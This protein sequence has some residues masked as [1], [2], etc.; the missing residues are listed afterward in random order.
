MSEMGFMWLN[1][2][3]FEKY[4]QTQAITSELH[5][6]WMMQL[7]QSQKAAQQ[8]VRKTRR[9]GDQNFILP[10]NR[11]AWWTIGAWN[12]FPQFICLLL[13]PVL[14]VSYQLSSMPQ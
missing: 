12:Y 3:T 10:K 4:K 5:I 6:F 8:R 1:A 11:V 13:Y 9:L 7:A 2:E 14:I